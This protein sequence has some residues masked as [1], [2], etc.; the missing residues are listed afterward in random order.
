MRP[1]IHDRIPTCTASAQEKQ[2][3]G[4]NR[5]VA[6]EPLYQEYTEKQVKG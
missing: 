3:I 6:A 2:G 4:L 1:L 5:P